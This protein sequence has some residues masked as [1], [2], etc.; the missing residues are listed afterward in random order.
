MRWVPLLLLL[1]GCG[2]RVLFRGEEPVFGAVFVVQQGSQRA[3][4]FGHPDAEDQSSGAQVIRV[5]QDRATAT[6]TYAFS[7]RTDVS[8]TVLYTG[9]FDDRYFDSTMFTAVDARVNSAV[10]VNLAGRLG[11]TERVALFG[12]ID[13]LFDEQYEQIYGYGTAGL[14][15]YAG[16]S[17]TL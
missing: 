10:V 17:M 8:A 7:S 11:V 9:A 15:A 12:R 6:A 2:P 4:R 16:V 3:L 5:P 1:A 14:S 13:N